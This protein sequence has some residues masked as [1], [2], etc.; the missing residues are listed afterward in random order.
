MYFFIP[1]LSQDR[2]LPEHNDGLAKY[3]CNSLNAS[4]TVRGF[5]TPY[6]CLYRRCESSTEPG[7]F[8][9]GNESAPYPACCPQRISS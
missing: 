7:Y 9:V 2:N 5:V 4:Y 3:N 6:T 1:K 8:S